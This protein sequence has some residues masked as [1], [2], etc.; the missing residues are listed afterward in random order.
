MLLDIIVLTPNKIIFKG[1]A[2]SVIV[3]GEYGIFEVL[4]FHKRILGRLIRG[5][6]HIDETEVPIK[7]GLVKA[8]QNK[9]TVIVEN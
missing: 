4:P 6:V 2:K 3:P 5:T 9:V 7:R 8:G 1:Q